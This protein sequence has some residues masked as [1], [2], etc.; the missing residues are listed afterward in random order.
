MPGPQPVVRGDVKDQAATS[1]GTFQRGGV[2]QIAGD[3]FHIQFRDVAASAQEGA[4]R[5][6]T[7][8]EQAGDMPSEEPGSSRDQ[9]RFPAS[10]QGAS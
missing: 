6:P 1:H 10:G 5:V 7:L 4:N 9:N 8:Q 2:A 3:A